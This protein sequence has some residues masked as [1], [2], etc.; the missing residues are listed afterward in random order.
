MITPIDGLVMHFDGREKKMKSEEILE[1]QRKHNEQML[2]NKLKIARQEHQ[3]I[4]TNLGV[5]IV[6]EQIKTNSMALFSGLDD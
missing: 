6:S 4:M 1:L 3:S 2:E 5:Y